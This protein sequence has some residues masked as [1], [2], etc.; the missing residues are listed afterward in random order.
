MGLRS[1]LPAVAVALLSTALGACSSGASKAGGSGGGTEKQGTTDSKERASLASFESKE[2]I[3]SFLK[4]HVKAQRRR[5]GD[6]SVDAAAEASPPPASAPASP[7]PAADKAA[8]SV[9]NNQTAGVD[10]GGI[11]KLH[12]EYLVV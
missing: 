2:E 8:D 6:G 10:E 5:A 1:V 12:G 9:T 3:A 7:A 4:E 11:V